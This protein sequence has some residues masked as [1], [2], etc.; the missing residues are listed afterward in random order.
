MDG[1]VTSTVKRLSDAELLHRLRDEFGYKAAGP[2]TATTRSVYEKKLIGFI[3]DPSTSKLLKHTP[4]KRQS[5]DTSSQN[6]GSGPPSAEGKFF[7]Y[8]AHD[9]QL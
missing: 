3:N 4:S 6:G 5:L 8:A 7:Y 1:D 9:L 2:I